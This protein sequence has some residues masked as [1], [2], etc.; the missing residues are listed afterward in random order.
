[1]WEFES[2][3]F[4][5]DSQPAHPTMFNPSPPRVGF[6]TRG[7]MKNPLFDRH[8][9]ALQDACRKPDHPEYSK[10]NDELDQVIETIKAAQPEC[11][12]T[13]D[14]LKARCFVHAP[15]EGREVMHR[16][17]IRNTLSAFERTER[18]AFA[19]SRA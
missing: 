7:P 17:S 6:F 19:N 8:K 12:L 16:Y 15:V 14:D 10:S 11:F 4:M 3:C 1:M 2:R 5:R 13:K 18:A 9:L